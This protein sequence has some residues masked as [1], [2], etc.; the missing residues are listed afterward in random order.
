MRIII[1]EKYII[2]Y[3]DMQT[4]MNKGWSGDFQERDVLRDKNVMFLSQRT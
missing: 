1:K 3:K 4:P 2:L